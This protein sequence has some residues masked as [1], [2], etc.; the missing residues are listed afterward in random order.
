MNSPMSLT[1]HLISQPSLDISPIWTHFITAE[2][3]YY[4]SIQCSQSAI[5]CFLCTIWRIC[6][7]SD[8]FYSDS[9]LVQGL[10]C[11]ECEHC[12]FMTALFDIWS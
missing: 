7:I 3:K 6:L 1:D 4:N 5:I 11:V 2:V 8:D 9:C 10:T 12:K